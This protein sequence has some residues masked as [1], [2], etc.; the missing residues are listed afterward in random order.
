MTTN[1]RNIGDNYEIRCGDI[2]HD[3]CHTTASGTCGVSRRLCGDCSRAD[4]YNA[5]GCSDLIER[6][7]GR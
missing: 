1:K 6:V 3:H 2:M 4:G 7:M 5:D